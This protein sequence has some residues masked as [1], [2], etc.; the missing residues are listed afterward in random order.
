M[1]SY[2]TSEAKELKLTCS[3]SQL[4][5]PGMPLRNL[6]PSPDNQARYPLPPRPVSASKTVSSAGAASSVGPVDAD[7][8]GSAED[9]VEAA[10]ESAR[11]RDELEKRREEQGV[12]REGRRREVRRAERVMYSILVKL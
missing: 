2:K 3:P 5:L 1:K 6:A 9:S 7:S 4:V 11:E 12:E 10:G 8:V